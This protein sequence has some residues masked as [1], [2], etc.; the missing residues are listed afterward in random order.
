MRAPDARSWPVGCKNEILPDVTDLLPSPVIAIGAIHYDTIAHAGE[1]IRPE[2]STP[3]RFTSKPGGV[4]TNLARSLARLGVPVHLVGTV[5]D[6]GAAQ[7][8][9]RQLTNEGVL[10]A[11]VP[12]RGF[13]TGQYLALHDPSGALAAACVDDRVLAEAPAGLFDGI[14]SDLLADLPNETLWF[15]DAN[16]PADMLHGILA[17]IRPARLI[18]N[19]VSEAKAHR[20]KPLL[21]D[22]DCLMLNRGEAIALTDLAENT[23]DEELAAALTSAG[24]NRFVLTSGAED[25]LVLEDGEI[26]RFKPRR[27][28]V[29]DVTGAG[30]ALMAGTLAALARGATLNT[31]VP[32]GMAAAALTLTSTG[33]LA[34]EL[35]W[36]ALQEI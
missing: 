33:A 32:L 25:V 26:S 29:V 6:D 23:P 30:D 20:L 36:Q 19:A 2:T 3:A 21:G 27:T 13:A 1:V 17:Q 18:V 31:A 12:R 28:K 9:T 16:L 35:S 7:E 15:A 24:L 8:L 11:T 10:L 14:L 34:E 5:G 22:L 4:A